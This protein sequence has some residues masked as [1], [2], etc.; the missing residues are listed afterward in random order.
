[1]EQ[2]HRDLAKVTEL[3]IE[4][5]LL[6]EEVRLLKAKLFGRSSE[7]KKALSPDEQP[8]LFCVS[9]LE[10][11]ESEQASAEET[12]TY[13]RRKPRGKRK[14]IP[15]HFP[16][17]EVL[18][19][20][21]DEEKQCACGAKRTRIGEETSEQ[22][23]L[24]PAKVEVIRHVR[25]K[26]ACPDCEGLESTNGAVVI[27][28]APESMIPKSLAGPGLLADVITAKFAD[29]IPFYRHEKRLARL[30]IELSRTVMCQWAEKVADR[31]RPLIELMKRTALSLPY[32]QIDETPIRV[33]G[34]EGKA[35]TTQSYMWAIRGAPRDGPQ[36]MLYFY[37]PTRSADF[38]KT[39]LL[40]YQG[41]VHTDGYSGYG[42]LEKVPGV[43]HLGCWTH[44]RRKFSETILATKKG[45]GG[46]K[47]SKAHRVL[48]YFGKL[49]QHEREADAAGMKGDSRAELR[50]TKSVP[51][52]QALKAELDALHPKVPPNSTL[53]KAI[54][55]T[56]NQW[57]KLMRCLEHGEARLDTNLVE[58]AIRPLVLGRKNWLHSGCPKGAE[59]NA[60]LFSMIETA[61]VNGWEPYAY[62]RF[63]FDRLPQTAP[64]AYES[65]LPYIAKPSS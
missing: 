16:R 43:A 61:K 10:S 14:P 13:T 48:S 21:S 33:H 29:A 6:R 39:L 60:I 37:S 27:A 40:E 53:G 65:L 36:V 17:R 3:E 59:S 42:F 2:T 8:N 41:L 64:E 24:I 46:K 47:Q 51:I 45:K 19:D 35:N 1:M 12:V 23:D 57:P 25:P 63:L 54:G 28:P 7:S 4:N 18:H 34:E 26:Y 58:N 11:D 38:A 56:R 62:L 52:A 20:I 50:R 49:Y 5:K 15:D 44:A 31:C 55:Y 32:L 9:E 30:G 22:I